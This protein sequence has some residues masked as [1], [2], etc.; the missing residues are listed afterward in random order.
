MIID[1]HVHYNL[2]PLFDHWREYLAKARGLGVNQA[3]VVGIDLPSS[4]T[5]TQIAQ[6][7]GVVASIGIHPQQCSDQV[8][9][10]HKRGS[11]SLE[12]LQMSLE[13][14]QQQLEQLEFRNVVAIGETGLDYYHLPQ[15]DPIRDL[16][17]Q[18]QQDLFAMQIRLALKL[19]LPV[20]IHVRDRDVSV[21][22]KTGNAYWDAL[23]LMQLFDL[24]RFTLHCASGPQQYISEA[25]EMGGFFGF[26][27]NL[28]YQSATLVREIFLSVP[29]NK[30][31]VET[32]A[33]YLPPRAF[34][35][36]MCEPAM[37]LETVEF[38]EQELH[39]D[40]KVLFENAKKLFSL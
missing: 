38:I 20:V 16:T 3:I 8:L 18:L 19:D 13:V 28:T 5:A 10:A 24:K 4:L 40:R 30:R 32:D 17:I 12:A 34:R 25:V 15:S 9:E 11:L 35:G 6:E 27:G 37:I 39:T 36:K 26:D 14:Q 29:E 22:K 21:E 1:T 31:V 23:R 33:P 2:E 7:G